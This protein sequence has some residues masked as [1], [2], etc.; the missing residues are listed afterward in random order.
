MLILR[1]DAIRIALVKTDSYTLRQVVQ[2]RKIPM[3]F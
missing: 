2:Q 1:E 3:L